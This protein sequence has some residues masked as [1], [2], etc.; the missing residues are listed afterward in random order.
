VDLNRLAGGFAGQ[1]NNLDKIV[2]LSQGLLCAGMTAATLLSNPANLFKAVGFVAASVGNL[3]TNAIADR[4]QARVNNI[5]QITSLGIRLL[6]SYVESAQNILSNLQQIY[7]K[8]KKKQSNLL[9]FIFN[10]QNCAIQAANFL[11]CISAIIAKKITKKVL[12]KI[13]N[14]FDRIQNEV[15]G[16]IYNAGGVMEQ[17]AG[18]NLRS[19]EKLTKQ[20]NAML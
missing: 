18:R 14:E 11:N 13:D 19:V 9:D 8:I 17:H 2:K 15:A 20:L 6:K 3:I 1:L 12:P 7:D 5:L 4:M 10:T 16:A